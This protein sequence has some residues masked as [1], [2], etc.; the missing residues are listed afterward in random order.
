MPASQTHT[1]GDTLKTVRP[2]TD[3]IAEMILSNVSDAAFIQNDRQA[4]ICLDNFNVNPGRSKRERKLEVVGGT[5][6]DPLRM[7]VST[8][9]ISLIILDG[10]VDIV[11]TGRKPCKVYMSR[12]SHATV[13][14]SSKQ[15]I[16][17]EGH[18]SA[19]VIAG[20]RNKVLNRTRGNTVDYV[21]K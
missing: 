4:I 6:E 1:I 5:E 19:T 7:H 15:K 13:S 21:G 10:H 8:D 11:F 14:A 18:G 12:K 20:I 16:T 2:S 9:C 17:L 3:T